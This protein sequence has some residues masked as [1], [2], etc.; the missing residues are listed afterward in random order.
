MSKTRD[1]FNLSKVVIEKVKVNQKEKIVDA[2]KLMGDCM[3]N[4]GVVQLFGIDH[5]LAF[6]MELGYRAGGLMPFHQI[7]PTDLAL[8]DVM[9]EEVVKSPSFS[10]DAS[11]AAKL[12]SIYNILDEDM[13]IL[14]SYKGNEPILVETALMAKA[15]NQKVIVV[16]NLETHNS[17]NA[18]HSSG[19]KLGDLADIVIDI[20]VAS[21]DVNVV[22]GEYKATQIATVSGN[23]IAQMLT[24]ETY[25]YLQDNNKDCP[26]LLSANVKGADVHNRAISDKYFGRW[27]S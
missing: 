12:L 6:S 15:K 14:I 9:N 26:V 7:I 19:K 21:P 16:T 27:N 20:M 5:G 11:N 13:F 24:A 18:V 4:N 17:L 8:R 1:F 3:D 25:R 10:Q 2:A 22:V 23:I